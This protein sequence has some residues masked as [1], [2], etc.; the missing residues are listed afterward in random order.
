[1]KDFKLKKIRPLRNEVLLTA[2]RF[3][4]EDTKSESGVIRADHLDALY[5]VQEI[6]AVSEG[7][8]RQ[9]F[10]EGQM[11]TLNMEKFCK[12]V[13]AEDPNSLKRDM[14]Q[15][16]KKK[17]VFSFPVYDIDGQEHL[18]VDCY[19]LLFEVT[20]MEVVEGQEMADSSKPV[21]EA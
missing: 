12:E 20:E 15:V 4:F 21:F 2:K 10:T 13:R 6:V 5:P 9:G 11:V 16:Y 18:L 14:E 17:K 7:A 8:R 3:T 1:M 19:D